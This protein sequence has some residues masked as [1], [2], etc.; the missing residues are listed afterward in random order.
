[1]K[2]V[3]AIDASSAA[4]GGGLTYLR[5][6]LPRLRDD[7]QIELGPV[8]LRSQAT[9]DLVLDSRDNIH[10]VVMPGRL[11]ALQRRW[12]AVLAD[13]GADAVFIPTELSLRG[14]AIPTVF[15]LRNVLMSPSNTASL[16]ADR[17][18]RCSVQRNLARVTARRASHWI[19]VSDVARAVA[20]DTFGVPSERVS[21]IYH[22]GP[23]RVSP[24]RPHRPVQRVVV[25]SNIYRHK[26]LEVVVAALA[27]VTKPLELTVVG[28]PIDAAYQSELLALVDGV[29]A[30]HRV[31]FV[32]PLYGDDLRR[33]YAEADCFVWPSLAE[34]FGLPLLEA[35]AHGLPIVA[36]DTRSSHEIAGDAAHYFAPQQPGALAAILERAATSG[37]ATGDLPRRY[38][39]DTTADRTAGVLRQAAWPSN[40]ARPPAAG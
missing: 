1:M 24:P 9:A 30:R 18:F 10:T 28:K 21:V 37:L 17:R 23:D 11:A 34:S 31:R 39:W 35:H 33:Q 8:L 22:G 6:M 38:S 13:A 36:S 15:A 20:L 2:P 7:P 27:S 4:V 16:T 14:Y 5:E 19:A 40:G 29:P 32:G 26:N 12:S 3:V 25:V